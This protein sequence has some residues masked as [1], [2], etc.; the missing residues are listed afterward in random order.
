MKKICLGFSILAVSVLP[1]SALPVEDVPLAPTTE[2]G[3]QTR[4]VV[5][6]INNRHYLRDTIGKLDGKEIIEAYV[7][8]F[9][10]GQMH[11]LQSDL[12]EFYFRFADAM[13]A[14]LQKGNLY[15]AF[16][17]FKTFRERIE[18]C[19]DWI[20][21]RLKQDFDF[22]V[23]ESFFTDRKKAPWPADASEADALWER[24]IKYE[25]INEMLSLASES[26][27]DKLDS[28]ELQQMNPDMAPDE[29]DSEEDFDPETVLRLLEDPEYYADILEQA[30]TKIRRRY[31]RRLGRI[32]QREAAE[33]QE[34]YV[35]SMTQLFDPHSSFLS[36]DT[37]ENFNSAVQNS[38][39][40][41]GA[42][43]QD[44][45]GICTIKDILPGGPAEASRKL[46]AGDEILGVAQGKDGEFEDIVDMQLRYVV[47]KIKGKKGTVVR[48][49]IHPAD[50]DPSARKDV[51]IVRDEVKLT[52]NLA[53]A[54]LI[55]VPNESGTPSKIGVIHLPS[56]YGNIGMGDNLTTTSADIAELL[57][58]LQSSGAEGL[59][60]DLRNN[61]GGLLSEA[62]RVAGLFIPTGPVVQVRDNSGRIDVLP[63]NDPRIVWRGP[64]I[65]LTSRFSASASEIVAGALRDHGR[66]LV[67]GNSSTHGKGT[68]QEVYHMN[69]RPVFSF[70]PQFSKPASAARPVASK[71]TIK[72]FYLPGGTSTQLEGVPSDIILPSSNE[73]LPIG[74]SDL[75]HALPWNQIDPLV[76]ELDWS[77]LGVAGAND[78]LLI[79]ALE[80]ASMARQTSLEEFDFLSKQI[81]WRKKRFEEKAV[82]IHLAQR[83]TD[84]IED[85]AYAEQLNTAYE[86]LRE[87]NYPTEE[88]L[89]KISEEQ[90]ALSIQNLS[91]EIETEESPV[92]TEQAEAMSDPDP[93]E[94][95]NEEEEEEESFD[96]YLRET[97]RIMAD[98][99]RGIAKEPVSKTTA[100]V[101]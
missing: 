61:G 66:A 1:L 68:V 64:L 73:F 81:A 19:T 84:K 49:L 44:E 87:K 98:W 26:K 93:S 13:E 15:A 57:N 80:Q 14:F 43:L 62:V 38:F 18:T 90:E 33:V 34:A 100:S 36:A 28:I 74:E 35:N 41:I 7:K 5:N 76:T 92:K 82:S 99:V 24:R 47:R 9:D 42:L 88:F 91:L 12:D 32:K 27:L 45:D 70:L 25:L 48:L 89:T 50:T 53:T 96:I 10:Y 79:E 101:E 59:V 51:S 31:D 71:I 11:F 20:H 78:P 3:D 69:N 75:P 17:I 30:K 16:E 46:G 58:K 55:E 97:A 37:L 95:D 23:E 85:E 54:Q 6:T 94:A 21:A 52:A 67:I 63:D 60:L 40:G 22:S 83:I 29:D 56:F 39:V 72:Q 2:M 4:W 65:V 8:S 77:T 86:A